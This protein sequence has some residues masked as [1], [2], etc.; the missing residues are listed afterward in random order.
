MHHFHR[1]CF[2]VIKTFVTKYFCLLSYYILAKC[3]GI[4]TE[5]FQVWACFFQEDPE[6]YLGPVKHLWWNITE[7]ATGGLL[8]KKLS[9]LR[10]ATLLKKRLWHKCFLV[11]FVKF[12]R[13]PFLQNTSGRLLHTFFRM[14]PSKMF[15]RVLSYASGIDPWKHD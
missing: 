15:G 1:L 4:C 12:L 13:T 2:F 7:A 5:D 11:N 3:L 6:A 9:G 8:W 10:P 14:V